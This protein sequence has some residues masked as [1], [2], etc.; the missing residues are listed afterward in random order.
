MESNTLT[1]SKPAVRWLAVS[2]VMMAGCADAPNIPLAVVGRLPAVERIQDKLDA[3]NLTIRPP[4]PGANADAARW[5]ACMAPLSSRLKPVLIQWL[6]SAEADNELAE[7]GI[8][9]QLEDGKPLSDHPLITELLDRLT[10]APRW[11]GPSE[12]AGKV[13]ADL[14]AVNAGLDRHLAADNQQLRADTQ[15][16]LR[17]SKAYLNAYFKKGAAVAA[18]RWLPNPEETRKLQQQAAGLLKL[19]ADDPELGEA[20]AMLYKRLDRL[21]DQSAGF[22]GRD[23]SQFGFP[24]TVERNSRIDI[25]HSQVAADTL[26][27]VLEALRDSIAPLPVL[28]QATAAASLKGYVVDFGKPLHWIYDR[29]DGAFVDIIIDEA[30]FQE[31]DAHARM[32]EASVAGAVG[33]AIRGGSW[34][35]LNNEA[36]AKLVETAAGV[37]ARHM[38]ERADWCLQAEAGD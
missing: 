13:K 15:Q 31:I 2:A 16:A 11:S 26:R 32:A 38:T 10:V 30:R 37:L 27:V 29:R 24:G 4:K 28:P 19:K 20:L 34:G 6:N 1:T 22:V 21:A 8:L 18:S 17:L 33:K 7:I 5:H 3:L 14:A 35:A 25:D 9:A 36:V 12:L 23:G